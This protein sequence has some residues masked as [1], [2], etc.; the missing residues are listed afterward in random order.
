MHNTSYPHLYRNADLMK[1]N[2][3]NFLLIKKIKYNFLFFNIFV[4]IFFL[5]LIMK[6]IIKITLYIF[7]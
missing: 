3:F 1:I 4:F 5:N 2:S 6:L 7:K